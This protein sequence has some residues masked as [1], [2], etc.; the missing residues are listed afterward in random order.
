M[1]LVN[2]K[3]L[4]NNNK[5]TQILLSYSNYEC[6]AFKIKFKID[7]KPIPFNN[8]L[9]YLEEL[10]IKGFHV[11]FCQIFFLN[12]NLIR[13]VSRDGPKFISIDGIIEPPPNLNVHRWV[14]T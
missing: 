13:L 9:T 7:C 4:K 8:S 6:V 3:S 14:G 1:Q 2:T 11:I 12:L 10:G 5:R